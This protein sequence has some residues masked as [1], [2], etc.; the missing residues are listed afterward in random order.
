MYYTAIVPAMDF[1]RY[2]CDFGTKLYGY[3]MPVIIIVSGIAMGYMCY[4]K[5]TAVTK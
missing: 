4:K 2:W 1:N 3:T 5:F